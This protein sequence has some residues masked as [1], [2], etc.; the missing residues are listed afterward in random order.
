MVTMFVGKAA[1]GADQVAAATKKN[2]HIVNTKLVIETTSCLTQVL[3]IR[4]QIF[5]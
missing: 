3:H 1:I 4:I 2:N 5:L